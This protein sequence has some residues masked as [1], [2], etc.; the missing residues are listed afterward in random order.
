MRQETLL[1]AVTDT[2]NQ[3]VQVA[4]DIEQLVSRLKS[5]PKVLFYQSEAESHYASVSMKRKNMESKIEQLLIDLTQRVIDRSEY[6][7]MKKQYA[8]KYDELLQEETKA[9]SDIR[10][11]DAALG[12]TEKWLDAI[13]RY[14]K[15]PS[16]DRALLNLLVARIEVS[17]DREIKIILN[18]EDPYQPIMKFLERIEGIK[19]VS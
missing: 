7:Y 4:V 14:Q 8:K 13:K 19:D 3:Q 16:I 9:L 12:A 10:V 15:I 2:L 5:M 17:K 18:Y 11:R 1:K 6:D